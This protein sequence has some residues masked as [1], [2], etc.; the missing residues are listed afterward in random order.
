M[1]T[2]THLRP[3]KVVGMPNTKHSHLQSPVELTASY[4][5]MDPVV[6]RNIALSSII[7]LPCLDVFSYHHGTGEPFR[8]GF[9]ELRNHPY[10]VTRYKSSDSAFLEQQ[11]QQQQQP[12]VQERVKGQLV[13]RQLQPLQVTRRRK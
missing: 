7:F 6:W 9:T 13:R 3:Y 4:T 5:S 1:E 2:V 8:Q 12:L 11:Q 10:T